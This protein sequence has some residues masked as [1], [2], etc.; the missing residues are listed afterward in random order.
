[1]LLEPFSKCA[2]LA[3][4]AASAVAATAFVTTLVMSLAIVAAAAILVAIAVAAFF[5]RK[6]FAVQTLGELFGSGFA[7]GEHFAAE[8]EGF[9]GHGVVEVHHH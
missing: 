2:L 9:A 8:V 7:Y 6:K 4:A 5:G 1:M 3:V